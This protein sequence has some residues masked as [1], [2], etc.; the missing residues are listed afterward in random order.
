MQTKGGSLSIRVHLAIWMKIELGMQAAPAEGPEKVGHKSSV[1]EPAEFTLGK[2]AGP[3][4][5]GRR[6]N[7]QLPANCRFKE[8]RLKAQ[9]AGTICAGAL[10]KQQN[11]NSGFKGSRD[12]LT[13]LVCTGAASA[14]DENGSPT[15]SQEAEDRPAADLALGYER[16]GQHRSVYQDVEVTEVVR[17]DQTL[18]GPSAPAN[19]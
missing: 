6:C 11:G 12:F 16:A 8:R 4:G 18:R 13:R 10:G 1:A 15:A 9:H 14:V 17:A 7:H 3:V 19:N 5:D 2:S